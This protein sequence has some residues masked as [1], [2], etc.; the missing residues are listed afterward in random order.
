[1]ATEKIITDHKSYHNEISGDEAKKRLKTIGNHCYLTRYSADWKCYV[2][3]VYMG[4]KEL[5]T[6]KCKHFKLTISEEGVHFLNNVFPTLA[7]M[8]G[9]YENKRFDPAFPT[10]G[11]CITV[12]DYRTKVKELREQSSCN[13]I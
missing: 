9:E 3:S 4:D 7:R 12:G 1:M 13:L 5:K 6:E 10:I 2:L 11:K 8:L